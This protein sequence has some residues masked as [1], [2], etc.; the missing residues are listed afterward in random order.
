MAQN[1]AGGAYGICAYKAYNYYTQF[2]HSVRRGFYYLQRFYAMGQGSSAVAHINEGYGDGRLGVQ[3]PL[4]EVHG[5]AADPPR[6]RR[7]NTHHYLEQT[8]SKLVEVR[9]PSL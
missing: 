1:A 6:H 4:F 9:V 2:A 8:S 3:N 5:F 7:R